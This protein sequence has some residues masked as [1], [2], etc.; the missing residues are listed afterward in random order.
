M[1]GFYSAR[2]R[3]IPPLPW[4]VFAPPLS[5]C[6]AGFALIYRAVYSPFGRVL[7]AIKGNDARA[8]SLGYNTDAFKLLAFT[9]SAGLA[10]TAGSLKALVFQLASLTDLFYM[11]SGNVLLMVLIGGIGTIWGPIVG[12]TIFVSAEQYLA[13]TGSWVLILQGI[14]F[15]FCVLA[16]RKG[17]VGTYLEWRGNRR[18]RS[19]YAVRRDFGRV[20]VPKKEGKPS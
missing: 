10:G 5:V 2:G 14:V 7:K 16:F 18:A 17:V 20:E 1:A 3:T 19:S 12:A 8:T 15:I 13:H 11:T 6:A 4:P 9:L